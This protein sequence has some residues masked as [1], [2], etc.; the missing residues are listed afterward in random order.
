VLTLVTAFAV[1]PLVA[2]ACLAVS[3]LSRAERVL[4]SW[5]GLK[6]AVPLLLAAF[7]ALELLEGAERVQAIVLVATAASI[8]VQGA[9]LSAVAGRVPAP[10]LEGT[11]PN[12]GVRA[13]ARP[14]SASTSGYPWRRWRSRR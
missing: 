1:R 12:A 4:V 5:G 6:G 8:V 14:A 2:A 9:T 10:A 11:N 7:P 3:G 13:A